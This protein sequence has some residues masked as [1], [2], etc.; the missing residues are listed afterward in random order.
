M[1][2]NGGPLDPGKTPILGDNG[3]YS[4]RHFTDEQQAILAD[5]IGAERLHH[6][7]EARDTDGNSPMNAKKHV[8][9]TI[10]YMTDIG[11]VG[12]DLCVD[13]GDPITVEVREFLHANLDEWLDRSNGTGRFLLGNANGC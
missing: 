4:E 12:S 9:G 7:A 2:D 3:R 11:P 6:L 8:C 13:F 5:E 10:E 1:K